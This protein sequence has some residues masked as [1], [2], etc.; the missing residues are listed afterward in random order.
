ME[1]GERERGG[2]RGGGSRGK[3]RERE[4][5]G[6]RERYFSSDLLGDEYHIHDK[7]LTC[8]NVYNLFLTFT[9]K[10]IL[11]HRSNCCCVTTVVYCVFWV[12]SC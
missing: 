5:E 1:W 8:G 7:T 3:G 2:S 6:E 11:S 12:S 9:C 4:G 10:N